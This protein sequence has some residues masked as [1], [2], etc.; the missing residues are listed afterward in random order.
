MNRRNNVVDL[1]GRR[2]EERE[3]VLEQ[4]FNEHGAALRSFVA[5]NMAAD[6]DPEDIVQEVFIRLVKMDDLYDRLTEESGSTRSYL[7]TIAN[8]LVVDLE[9]KKSRRRGFD[10]RLMEEAEDAVVESNP[11]VIVSANRELEMLKAV[12]MKLRPDLRR[13]FVL[14]RFKHLSYPQ[15]AEHMGVTV[16]QVEYFMS[17]ALV[18][19]RRARRQARGER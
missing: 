1:M 16:K 11:E 13:A 10:S 9:R 6:E 12:I 17:Q 5:R 8:N 7:F 4:L 15:V 14:N 19:I 3:R 18:Q 2:Q